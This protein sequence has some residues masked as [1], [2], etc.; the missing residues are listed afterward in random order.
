MNKDHPVSLKVSIPESL[1]SQFKAACALKK[2]TMNEALICLIRD[3]LEDS[4]CVELKSD[5]P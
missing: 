3:W 5:K 2:I 4:I 1:R